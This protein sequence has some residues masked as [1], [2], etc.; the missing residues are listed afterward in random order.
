MHFQGSG[1]GVSALHHHPDMIRIR[2][3]INNIYII[4]FFGLYPTATFIFM[5]H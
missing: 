4:C 3:V 2:V 5:N 1:V